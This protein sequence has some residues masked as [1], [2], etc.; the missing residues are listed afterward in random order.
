MKF[1]CAYREFDDDNT[2]PSIR[3]NVSDIAPKNKSEILKH[4]KSG[5]SLFASAARV[6]DIFTS[7]ATNVELCT[8]TDGVYTWTSEEMYYFD[9][10]NLKLNDD[11]IMTIQ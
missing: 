7:K 2:L 6:K 4:L 11:F 1:I 3:D 5:K 9:K 10:Y 8:F